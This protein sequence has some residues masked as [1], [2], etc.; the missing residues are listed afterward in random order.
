MKN[1]LKAFQYFSE[2]VLKTE[3]G[4]FFSVNDS[5][6]G[7]KW[8]LGIG[9]YKEVDFETFPAFLIFDWKGEKQKFIQFEKFYSFDD[10][11]FLQDFEASEL[12]QNVLEKNLKVDF[13]KSQ[14][15]RLKSQKIRFLKQVQSV[16]AKQKNGE[17]WVL[18]LAENFE[19][20]IKK[21]EFSTQHFLNLFYKFLK[22]KKNH[23]GGVVILKDQQFASFSPE[24]FIHQKEDKIQSFP[25]KGTGSK[26]YLEN[27]EKEISEIDMIIDLIR[28]DLGQICKKVSFESKRYLTDEDEF[29]HARAC[30]TGILSDDFLR[31]NYLKKLLPAGSISGAP[32]KK[33]IE[34]I[35]NLE[36]FS[37]NYFTGILGVKPSK[38]E[39][40]FNILI[41]T[42]FYDL[43]NKHY[44]YPVGVG[45]TVESNPEKEWLEL[46]QKQEILG[47]L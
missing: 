44:N 46:L 26:K 3:S 24:I 11:D 10:L 7:Q 19:Y 23:C 33:T 47:K 37:R 34:I 39:I 32:K 17:N 5:F 8:F 35:E 31:K 18:N 45:I 22:L 36:T 25:I 20:E 40:I 12:T 27:S 41:R 4:V 30:I 13:S 21:N 1:V 14:K 29:F 6:V 16:Q 9:K 2:Q 15:K 42:L 38:K 43:K 28:N